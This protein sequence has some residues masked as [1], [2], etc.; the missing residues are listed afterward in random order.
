MRSRR[1]KKRS[2]GGI[3]VLLMLLVLSGLGYCGF[4][5]YSVFGPN[6]ARVAGTE[7]FGV[8]E[9]RAAVMY[10]YELQ[11]AEALMEG[12]TCYLPADWVLANINPR[13][14]RD[15]EEK[16]LLYTLPDRIVKM[17]D[18]SVDDAGTPL[19]FE[20]T[21]GLY[22]SLPL[23]ETYTGIRAEVF[24]K[25]TDEGD[26]SRIFLSD[27]PEADT[28]AAARKRT[29]IRTRPSVKGLVVD[30]VPKGAQLRIIPDH[31]GAATGEDWQRVMTESGFTGYLQKKTLREAEEVPYINTFEAES[32]T[33]ETREGTIVLGWH[34]VTN[35]A[36]NAYFENAV[37]NAAPL[38]VISPTWF[39]LRG[40]DGEYECYASAEY[41]A[42]AH[43]RGMEVWALID[44]FDGS[45]TLGALLSRTSVREKLIASLMA[46][47]ETYGFDGFN[48]DFE[49]LRADAAPQYLEFVRE[50][51]V[52]CR[53]KGLVLSADVPNPASFN[54]HYGR[55]ELGTVCDYVIN[56]GYDEHTAGDS[57]GSTSSMGFF[58][59]G[60]SRSL[61][62]VP[63]ER[64]IAG[65]PFYTRIWAEA[66][67]GSVTSEAITM[68]N[69][70]DWVAR[71]DVPLTMD[72]D[73]GQFT[74]SLKEADGTARYIWMEDVLSVQRRISAVREA[75]TAGIACWRLG[76]EPA[77]VWDTVAGLMW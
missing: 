74:G 33:H 16:L 70:A 54:L 45:V 10:N 27:P 12:G 53:E 50:L 29:A 43:A 60:L 26:V 44:N 14:Y 66:E 22:L 47:A 46:D 13:F 62:E 59:S 31:P 18:G 30:D 38:N 25:G 55:A 65:I 49:Y 6:R 77:E 56:M 28:V 52:S 7:L 21:E 5:L 67:D 37:R 42:A 58:E 71:H 9:D 4:K 72:L 63:A 24:A 51:A 40:N 2:G 19:F 73:C 61:E 64:L 48:L 11:D 41:T 69:A 76:A 17:E 3:I 35:R 15:D 36:A 32:W 23:I 75:G 8:P 68:E 57:M 39:S 1:K 20:R 34:Q